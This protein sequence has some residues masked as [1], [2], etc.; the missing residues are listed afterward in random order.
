[1]TRNSCGKGGNSQ[2]WEGRPVVVLVTCY[3]NALSSSPAGIAQRRTAIKYH[4]SQ[5]VHLCSVPLN[6][7]KTIRQDEWH[8]FPQL[9]LSLSR[10]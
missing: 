10:E 9:V 5:L 8:L 4:F 1:M 3:G 6:L 7:T 2:D